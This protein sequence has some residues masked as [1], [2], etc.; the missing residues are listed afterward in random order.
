MESTSWARH[1]MRDHQLALTGAA[2]MVAAVALFAMPWVADWP[3]TLM[4]PPAIV[5]FVSGISLAGGPRQSLREFWESL[6]S[7]STGGGH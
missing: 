1:T 3:H 6:G 7:E 5:I 4:S 2:L